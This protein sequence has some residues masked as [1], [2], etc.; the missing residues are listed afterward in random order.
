MAVVLSFWSRQKVSA[1]DSVTAANAA[2]QF[3]LWC[4][5]FSAQDTCTDLQA[6]DANGNLKPLSSIFANAASGIEITDFEWTAL[7]C[8]ADPNEEFRAVITNTAGTAS[9]MQSGTRADDNGLAVGATHAT[10]GI[11]LNALS[12]SM[13]LVPC[14]SQQATLRGYSI[15]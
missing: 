14:G 8:T 6:V 11:H 4:S 1:A 13:I 10:T 2:N 3:T 5:T 7:N 9:I 12:S 15:P